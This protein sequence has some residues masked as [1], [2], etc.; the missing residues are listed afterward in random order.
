MCSFMCCILW[1]MTTLFCCIQSSIRVTPFLVPVSAFCLFIIGSWLRFAVS[2]FAITDGGW[3]IAKMR[4][5]RDFDPGNS[6]SSR[7]SLMIVFPLTVSLRA[8]RFLSVKVDSAI[9]HS[10]PYTGR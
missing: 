10:F 3:F 5:A 8:F 7:F 9:I 4:S 6:I 2:G 1:L